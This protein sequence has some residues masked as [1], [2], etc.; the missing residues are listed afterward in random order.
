MWGSRQ[1]NLRQAGWESPKGAC[2]HRHHIPPIA[3]SLYGLPVRKLG[4]VRQIGPVGASTGRRQ[5]SVSPDRH[6]GLLIA[7]NEKYLRKRRVKPDIDVAMNLRD[8]QT[9]ARSEDK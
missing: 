7:F 5:P 8:G 2:A 4:G 1:Q 9:L 3:Y 6:L